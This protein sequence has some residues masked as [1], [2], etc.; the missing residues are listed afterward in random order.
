MS[1][2]MQT[3][4]GLEGEQRLTR[5]QALLMVIS[6]CHENG[7]WSLKAG[8][9][10]IPPCALLVGWKDE[11]GDPVFVAVQAAELTDWKKPHTL[12]SIDVA[13]SV[14]EQRL[15]ED[16]GEPEYIIEGEL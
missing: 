11:P 7:S 13:R 14:L 12:R 4:L 3:E 5:A 16:P 8:L 9:T 10:K 15:G 6:R 1:R 2:G